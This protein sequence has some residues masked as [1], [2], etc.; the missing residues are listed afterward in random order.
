MEI[1]FVSEQGQ[2]IRAV[3]DVA[4]DEDDPHAM[5]RCRDELTGEELHLQRVEPDFK[6]SPARVQALLDR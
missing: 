5:L 6:L 1:F 3:L 2:R 4:E